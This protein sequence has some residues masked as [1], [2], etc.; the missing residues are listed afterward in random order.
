MKRTLIVIALIAALIAPIWAQDSG[1]TPDGLEWAKMGNGII[2]DGYTGTATDIRIPERINNLPV[3]EI[4]QD[5]FSMSMPGRILITSVVIPNTVTKIGNGAF[6]R[7]RNLT[8]VTLPSSLIEIGANAF[9]ETAI[10]SI[11]LPAS[12][13]TI[14]VNAFNGC[15]A[16]TTVSIPSSVTRITFGNNVFQ[17]ATNLNAVSVQALTNRGYVF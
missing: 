9:R 2:I 7:Q 17:G 14:G 5:V 10:T 13:R 3:V 1:T 8:S 4:W 6:S 11:S 12:I 15:T 16:L